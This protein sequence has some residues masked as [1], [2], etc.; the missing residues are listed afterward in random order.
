MGAHD[1]G[2]ERGLGYIYAGRLTKRALGNVKEP[3]GRRR[4]GELYQ[5][6]GGKLVDLLL[7]VLGPC[8]VCGAEPGEPCHVDSRRGRV[9]VH[10]NGHRMDHLLSTVGKG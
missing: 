4:M 1:N 3:I 10:Q 6:Q 2:S 8:R 9:Q 5:G 7:A